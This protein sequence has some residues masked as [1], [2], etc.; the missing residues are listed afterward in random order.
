MFALNIL[1][2]LTHACKTNVT[3]HGHY[4]NYSRNVHIPICKM[5]CT[6][7]ANIDLLTMKP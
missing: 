6:L 1:F 3:T 2:I 5:S 4:I 7:I